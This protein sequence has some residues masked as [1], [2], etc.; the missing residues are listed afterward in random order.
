VRTLAELDR[1]RRVRLCLLAPAAEDGFLRA[2]VVAGGRVAATRALPLE[3]G[4]LELEAALAAATRTEPA[5]PLAPEDA[6][7]LLLVAGFLR[8][9]P[10]ELRVLPLEPDRIRA[11]LRRS[12][13]GRAGSVAA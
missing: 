5:D 4:R 2:F 3:G 8:R 12:A 11:A 1:L 6:E 7:E 9:P 13:A 10:P